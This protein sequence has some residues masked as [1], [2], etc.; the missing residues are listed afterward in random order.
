MKEWV[1]GRMPVERSYQCNRVLQKA[2]PSGET[3]EVTSVGLAQ[4]VA[5]R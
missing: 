1:R 5:A 3:L 4:D 2:L